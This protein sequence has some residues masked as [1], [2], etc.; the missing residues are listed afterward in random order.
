MPACSVNKLYKK[1]IGMH[2]RNLQSGNTKPQ[3]Q[4][5]RLLNRKRETRPLLPTS[6]KGTPEVLSRLKRSPLAPNVY[7]VKGILKQT[8]QSLETRHTCT[9]P[10]PSRAPFMGCRGSY[11][12]K[13][14]LQTGTQIFQNPSIKEYTFKHIRDPTINQGTTL[15]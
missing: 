10:E 4:S 6:G 12:Q 9:L 5:K 2:W 1:R 11:S 8:H 3:I 13:G 14:N 15:D 7:V